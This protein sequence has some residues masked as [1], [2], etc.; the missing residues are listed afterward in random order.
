MPLT[1]IIAN[2]AGFNLPSGDTS[3]DSNTISDLLIKMIR[4]TVPELADHP[5]TRTDAM[6]DLGVNSMERGD[7][8]VATLETLNLEI[9]MT[10]LH[11]PRSIS[12]LADR[13]Y[14]K[15]KR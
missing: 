12:E 2:I 3:L 4:N 7:V 14:D 15:S 8:L 11:G 6:A 5:I 10:Q 1:N 13:I 9:P